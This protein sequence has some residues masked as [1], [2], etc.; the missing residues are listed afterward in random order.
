MDSNHPLTHTAAFATGFLAVAWIGGSLGAAGFKTVCWLLFHAWPE[1]TLQALVP[2]AAI[3]FALTLPDGDPLGRAL[4]FLLHLDILTLILTLPPLALIPCLAILLA[5][6]EPIPILRRLP[7]FAAA[8][9]ADV[10]RT[11]DPI[12]RRNRGTGDLRKG[13]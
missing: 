9:G 13:I 5:G 12:F 3:R 4:L 7:P 10:P 1:T 8:K 6:R 11:I 2:D